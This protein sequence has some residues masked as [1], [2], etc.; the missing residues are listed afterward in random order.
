MCWPTKDWIKEQSG[1]KWWKKIL[2]PERC[3]PL[4]QGSLL[5]V[6]LFLLHILTVVCLTCWVSARAWEDILSQYNENFQYVDTEGT[7]QVS[8]T[9]FWIQIKCK[10]K[11]INAAFGWKWTWGHTGRASGWKEAANCFSALENIIKTPLRKNSSNLFMHI[12]FPRK[13]K[14]P[15]LSHL[16]PN[17]NRKQEK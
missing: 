2:F 1:P 12:F 17:D 3:A 13:I 4:G 15:P 8:F 11:K 16:P 5:L 10:W 6:A 7:I 9:H 14:W